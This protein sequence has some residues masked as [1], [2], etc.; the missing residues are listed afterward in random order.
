M[1]VGEGPSSRKIP[2]EPVDL[3]LIRGVAAGSEECFRLFF[4]RWSGRL[5]RFLTRATGS[6]QTGEDLLQEAFLRVL[7]A[8]PRFEPRGEVS[9]WIYRICANLAYSHWRTERR[10]PLHAVDD[11]ES[12]PEAASPAREG[13]DALCLRSRFA[14][15]AHAMVDRLPA[16]QRIVFLMKV[17]QALTYEE[18]AV[19]LRCPVG[20]VKSRFHHA[21]R[22]LR[23]GLREW[24]NGFTPDGDATRDRSKV[25]GWN[26]GSVR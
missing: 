20:T 6:R 15:E 11:V 3:E 9:A 18:I 23:A 4:D 13:P 2:P 17:D 14:S 22:R 16:N 19:V 7:S 24:E 21:V 5:G 8:A 12:V 1:K 10:S 26:H 25:A